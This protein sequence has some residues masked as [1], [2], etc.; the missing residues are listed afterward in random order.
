MNTAEARTLLAAEL[1]RYRAQSYTALQRL[2]REQ[3]TFE[4]IGPSGTKYQVEILAHWDDRPE[5]DLRVAGAID[6]GGF[7]SFMP[8]GQ[9]FIVSPTGHFVGE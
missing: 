1:L 7:R 5:G 3:D 2:I 6:D 9:D 4:V 8:V